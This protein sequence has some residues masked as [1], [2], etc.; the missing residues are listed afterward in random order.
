MAD[1]NVGTR[2]HASSHYF[3][4]HRFMS[5]LHKFWGTGAIWICVQWISQYETGG[6]SLFLALKECK[7]QPLIHNV[8][9]TSH[10]HNLRTIQEEWVP[11]QVV[12]VTSS[13][14]I[15]PVFPSSSTRGQLKTCVFFYSMS[16]D[17]F[18]CSKSKIQAKWMSRVVVMLITASFYTWQ[19]SATSQQVVSTVRHRPAVRQGLLLVD[20]I[21]KALPYPL[22]SPSFCSIMALGKSASRPLFK[23]LWQQL[24]QQCQCSRWLMRGQDRASYTMETQKVSWIWHCWTEGKVREE[25]HG[26]K[27]LKSFQRVPTTVTCQMSQTGWSDTVR[28]NKTCSCKMSNRQC[29]AAV[30]SCCTV[31]TFLPVTLHFLGTFFYFLSWKGKGIAAHHIRSLILT[32]PCVCIY[33]RRY[34]AKPAESRV[35][36]HPPPIRPC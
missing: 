30:R 3:L 2:T 35:P 16:G 36:W 9:I 25:K 5:S 19:P 14:P 32:P 24:T 18:L 7:V 27:E 10:L 6:I 1:H 4:S 15:L 31:K 12:T 33:R 20:V 22:L 8:S 26:D 28:G 13:P 11:L 23:Y 29:T 17:C 34:V 21:D